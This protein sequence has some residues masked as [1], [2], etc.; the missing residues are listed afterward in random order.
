MGLIVARVTQKK[1]SEE[2]NVS[3]MTVSKALRGVA[4]ISEATRERVL[5]VAKRYKYVPNLL[6]RDLLRQRSR[7][8]GF[9]F[10]DLTYGY[11]QRIIEGAK[12]VLHDEEYRTLIG[13]TS[14]SRKEENSEIDLMLGCQVEGMICQPTFGG[15]ATFQRIVDY[16]IP[17]VFVADCLNISSASWVGLDGKDASLKIMEHLF[18]LGHRRIAFVAPRSV[19]KS[20]SLLP[21]LSGYKDFL[22][23]HDVEVDQ[24]LIGL[25]R[26]GSVSDICGLTNKLMSLSHPPTAIL[27]ISD[28]IAFQVMDC[29]MKRG[30]RVPED[31]SVAGMGGLLSSSYEMI[32]LTT[33][34]EDAHQIGVIAAKIILKQLADKNAVSVK[35]LLK[36]PLIVRRSTGRISSN[37]K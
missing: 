12:S 33:V 18:E 9:V 35:K 32:S 10:S 29:L 19:E 1:I 26:L 14:W 24:E 27:G 11:A 28:S 37:G 6:A 20:V 36:G 34:E 23:S 13:L 25:S 30:C 7:A 31:V 2:L 16:G 21:R 3:V 5:A 17:L 15:E 4:G 8:I 22:V